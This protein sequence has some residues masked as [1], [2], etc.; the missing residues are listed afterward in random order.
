MQGNASDLLTGLPW[1]SVMKSDGEVYHEPLRLLIVVQAPRE[2]IKKLLDHVP[3]FRQK[4][5]NGWIRLASI[6]SDDEWTSWS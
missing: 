6:D 2:Y 1:Q 4:V 5:R 3:E